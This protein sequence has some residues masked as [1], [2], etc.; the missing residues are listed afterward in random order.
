MMT[1]RG[2]VSLC[3]SI[4]GGVATEIFE[5]FVE[6]FYR[7]RAELAQLS[8]PVKITQLQ[9]LRAALDGW[10]IAEARALTAEAK[11]EEMEPD[12]AA[13]QEL[14]AAAGDFTMTQVAKM[15]EVKRDWL[16]VL[17]H[18]C[19][20]LYRQNDS[21]VAYRPV[22]EQKLVSMGPA[23]DIKRSDGTVKAMTIPHITPKGLAKVSR[24]V[25]DE[26]ERERKLVHLL[27]SNE[28]RVDGIGDY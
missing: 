25:L 16:Y 9:A 27:P 10:E 20:W 26:K 6:E 22:M 7:M 5:A 2:F 23:K 28:E 15:L 19:G 11:V 12:V 21:W 24:I 3:R 18:K 1:E 17:L 8:E 4:R 13:I 14:R